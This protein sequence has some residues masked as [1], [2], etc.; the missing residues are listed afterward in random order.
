MELQFALNYRP[1]PSPRGDDDIRI[2]K[3]IEFQSNLLKSNSIQMMVEEIQISNL[4]P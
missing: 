4:F 1:D 3:Y 2:C